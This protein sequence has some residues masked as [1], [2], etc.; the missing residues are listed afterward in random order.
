MRTP[1]RGS[2]SSKRLPRAVL[3]L[4]D[5]GLSWRI[6][7]ALNL[8]GYR[9]TSVREEFGRRRSG[10][11]DREIITWCTEHKAAWFTLDDDAKREYEALLRAGH[12]PVVW[13]RQPRAGLSE[14]EQFTR[15]VRYL[16]RVLTE[17]ANGTGLHFEIT[18]GGGFVVLW[19]GKGPKRERKRPSRRQ[20]P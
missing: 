4:L 3:C 16:E 11:D 9:F 15:I 1:T 8:V 13:I 10:P 7:E 5:K 12:V 18:T 14:R 6:A 20:G 17:L 19:D 2:R